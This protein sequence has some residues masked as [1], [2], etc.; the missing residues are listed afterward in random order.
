MLTSFDQLTIY[1]KSLFLNSKN[2][3]KF[4]E[5]E[6]ITKT[7]DFCDDVSICSVSID[8]PEEN[9]LLNKTR[10]QKSINYGY[11]YLFRIP[12]LYFT[13]NLSLI[14]VQ[15][16]LLFNKGY[17]LKYIDYFTLA[18]ANRSIYELFH[19]V[20]FLLGLLMILILQNTFK[21]MLSSDKSIKVKTLSDFLVFF[22]ILINLFDFSN[23]I[24]SIYS[25]K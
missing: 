14:I 7:D 18:D 23:C 3:D 1:I 5:K 24:I 10:S 12:I 13:I 22:G 16:Y 21:D 6:I 8:L 9:Y 20:S 25:S 4:L 19:I 17:S 15:L 2:A 11:I